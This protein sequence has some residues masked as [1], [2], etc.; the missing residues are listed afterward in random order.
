[1]TERLQRDSSVGNHTTVLT[2]ANG[3]SNL[4]SMFFPECVDIIRGVSNVTMRQKVL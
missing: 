2:H 4:C 3:S 1:M